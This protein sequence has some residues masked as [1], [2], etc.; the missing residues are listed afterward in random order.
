MSKYE[1]RFYDSPNGG[2]LKRVNPKGEPVND[3]CE[4]LTIEPDGASYVG[5]VRDRLGLIVRRISHPN[6]NT[7][8]FTHAHWYDETPEPSSMF[9]GPEDL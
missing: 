4:T 1:T 8:R 7:I 6:P 2:T 5:T 3:R 9:R